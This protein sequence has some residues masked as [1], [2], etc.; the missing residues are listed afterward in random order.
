MGS[1]TEKNVVP[2]FVDLDDSLIDT[3]LLFE[4]FFALLRSRPLYCLL[5]PFW[6]LHG[7]AHMKH[8]IA[9]HATVD[10]ASIP[11]N[12]P[13]LDVILAVTFY[14]ASVTS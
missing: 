12:R 13:F 3:D 6:L 9:Q 1:N 7:K 10:V 5:V 8:M 11:Y 4:S 2:L 14:Y